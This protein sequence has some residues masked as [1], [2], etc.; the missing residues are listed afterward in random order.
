[1]VKQPAKVNYF[2]GGAYKSLWRTIYKSFFKM[3]FLIKEST[4]LFFKALKLFIVA[5]FH[6]VGSVFTFNFPVIW[7]ATKATVIAL[8]N[9]TYAFP[10][11]L[12]TLV[13]A[14][15]LCLTL[16]GILLVVFLSLMLIIYLTYI[17]VYLLDLIFRKIKQLSNTCSNCQHKIKIPVYICPRCGVEHTK[18]I[19]SKYGIFKRKCNCGEKLPTIFLTGREKLESKCP[20]CDIDLGDTAHVDITIPVVGGPSAG[21]TCYIH[22]AMADIEKN[23]YND[24]KLEY[25]YDINNSTDEYAI[26]MSYLN[27]GS[28]PAKTSDMRLRFYRFYLK[29]KRAFKHLISLCDVGGEIYD[30]SASLGEQIAFTHTKAFMMIIDPLSITEYRKELEK[31]V[32]VAQYGPS[33]KEI[34]EVLTMLITTLENMCGISSKEM[35]NRDVA[36]V[37]SKADIP[38]L[39]EKIG[40]IAVARYMAN[41]PGVSRLEAQNAVCEEFL[42][43]YDEYGFINAV[44]SKFKVVQYFTCSALGHNED[45]SQFVSSGVSD[46]VYWIIDKISASINLSKIWGGTLPLDVES[47]DPIEAENE[48]EDEAEDASEEEDN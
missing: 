46:P 11:F 1:M 32:D 35:M 17:T 16:S 5:F 12:C 45:G 19:P 31:T 9:L 30:D 15:C 20:Y 8:W 39:N 24:H 36:I 38:G 7:E 6:F 23:A 41:N 43:E 28:V 40:N 3:L 4:V 33:A 2:F 14:P 18:L 47:E 21:K 44:K 42:K 13:F 27:D 29:P 25:E 22:M 26:N 10:V 48:A 34:D 37:F